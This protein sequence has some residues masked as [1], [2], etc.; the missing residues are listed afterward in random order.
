[1]KLAI[2]HGRTKREIDGAFSICG[3]R[4]DLQALAEQLQ[5]H[6]ADEG[7]S[8][9]WTT[10]YPRPT[11]LTNTPPIP[12]DAPAPIKQEV[13]RNCSTCKNGGNSSICNGCISNNRGATP[14][15]WAPKS[16]ARDPVVQS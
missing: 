12:W 15:Q 7:W 4:A 13:P 6:L 8:F 16:D 11:R 9:G 1:M 14:T 2:E 5:A 10:I 3:S